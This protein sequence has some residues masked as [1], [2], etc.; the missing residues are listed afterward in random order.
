MEDLIQLIKDCDKSIIVFHD[1]RFTFADRSQCTD[2]GNVE[3][4][5]DDSK[6]YAVKNNGGLGVTFRLSPNHRHR[7][8]LINLC[9]VSYQRLQET[10]M[11]AE[12]DAAR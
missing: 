8:E 10:A 11:T 2:L 4:I 6:A 7:N 9:I 1:D 3:R 5:L 12:R